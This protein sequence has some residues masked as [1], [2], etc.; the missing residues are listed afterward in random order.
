MYVHVRKH[1]YARTRAHAYVNMHEMQIHVYV[2][3]I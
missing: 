1:A 2:K 3:K